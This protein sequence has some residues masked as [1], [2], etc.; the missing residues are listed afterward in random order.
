MATQPDCEIARGLQEGKTD[1]WSALYEAY[2]ERVWW[3]VARRVGPEAQDVA[4]IVQETFLAAARSARSYDP[5][6]GSLWLW[7]G[8]IARNH[9]GTYRRNRQRRGRINQGGDLLAPV[10]EHLARCLEQCD[11]TPLQAVAS[12]E[13][14]TLVRAALDKLPGDYQSL[15]MA[16]YC[17]GN[18][19][20]R[21]ADEWNSTPT[22]IRSKLARA[23][24][25]FRR[26]FAEYSTAPDDHR[27]GAHHDS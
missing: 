18:S 5:A 20:E 14:A 11:V 6:K 8:G 24:R 25:A 16:R 21:I 26:A 27:A 12:A 23:R 19:V 9:V 13:R 4:D 1:A 15:L 17:D 2:F 10:A 7:L 22:A 3:S